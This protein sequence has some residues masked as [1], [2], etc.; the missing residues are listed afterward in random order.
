[1]I[2]KIIFQRLHF[3]FP[4]L[5]SPPAQPF[6]RLYIES[7]FDSDDDHDNPSGTAISALND[8]RLIFPF[9]KIQII[10]RGT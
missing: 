10:P 9:P 2:S 1:M 7:L 5:K 4:S 8:L 3:L 6:D